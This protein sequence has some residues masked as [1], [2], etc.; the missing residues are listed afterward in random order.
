MSDWAKKKKKK[1]HKIEGIF[2]ME[3]NKKK[4]HR[5]NRES[6]LHAI[7]SSNSALYGYDYYF[8]FQHLFFYSSE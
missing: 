3:D 6:A 2:L 5:L 4:K 1:S 7:T 8:F